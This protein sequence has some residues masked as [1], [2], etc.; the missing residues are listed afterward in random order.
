M[1]SGE[2]LLKWKYFLFFSHNPIKSEVW[3]DN[4]KSTLKLKAHRLVRSVV[5]CVL[6]CFISVNRYQSKCLNIVLTLFG[7]VCSWG[8]VEVRCARNPG[9]ARIGSPRPQSWHFDGF[10]DFL[11]GFG[12]RTKRLQIYFITIFHLL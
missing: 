9:I 1:D 12:A 7:R 6:K 11:V 4:S 8:G 3:F 10:A 2:T 5:V